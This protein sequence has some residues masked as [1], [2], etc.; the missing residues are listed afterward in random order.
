MEQ[1]DDR[2]V[3]EQERGAYKAGVI[4]LFRISV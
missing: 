4:P 2:S 1:Y 3:D